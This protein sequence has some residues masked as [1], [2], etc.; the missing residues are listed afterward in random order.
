VS[1]KEENIQKLHNPILPDVFLIPYIDISI[2]YR[3]RSMTQYST[4]NFFHAEFYE[5]PGLTSTQK[6]GLIS[7]KETFPL[8]KIENSLNHM[9]S[10]KFFIMMHFFASSKDI[11]FAQQKKLHR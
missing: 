6:V 8:L 4:S 11:K 2:H 5:D 9:E 3:G 7:I 1:R 10:L